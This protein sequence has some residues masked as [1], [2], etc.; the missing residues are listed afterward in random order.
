MQRVAA[1]QFTIYLSLANLGYAAG[2]AA[3]GPLHAGLPLEGLFLVL[4]GASLGAIALLRTVDL[5]G[6]AARL[7]RLDTAPDETAA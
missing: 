2:A 5:R 7:R 3:L 4:A 6:H 1:T